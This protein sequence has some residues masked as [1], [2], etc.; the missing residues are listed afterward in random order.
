LGQSNYR[1]GGHRTASEFYSLPHR[2]ADV[3]KRDRKDQLFYSK[4]CSNSKLIK[5]SQF[6]IMTDYVFVKVD[7][8]YI[9]PIGTHQHEF[10][11][12]AVPCTGGPLAEF[13][14]CASMLVRY[15]VDVVVEK[16]S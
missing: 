11:W 6:V 12:Q 4:Y 15:R 3:T 7:F 1:I 13:P 5:T 9:M 10:C 16:P 2:T 8:I 14:S